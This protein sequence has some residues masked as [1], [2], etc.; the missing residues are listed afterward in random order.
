MKIIKVS[1]C[2]VS[3]Y[4]N[5]HTKRR[6]LFKPA[7]VIRFVHLISPLHPQAYIITTDI[8]SKVPENP[9]GSHEPELR[10]EPVQELILE[11]HNGDVIGGGIEPPR[12]SSASP[13]CPTDLNTGP[14][15]PSEDVSN[16]ESGENFSP[17]SLK[18]GGSVFVLIVTM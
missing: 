17:S 11:V 14:K 15:I 12:S 1:L 10:S 16:N 2:G 3:I 7:Q 4:P 18:P 5:K 9:L 13:E 6:A 8:N